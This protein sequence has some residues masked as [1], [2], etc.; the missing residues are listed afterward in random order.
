MLEVTKDFSGFLVD[1]G[2]GPADL[3]IGRNLKV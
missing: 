3:A 2:S 1:F